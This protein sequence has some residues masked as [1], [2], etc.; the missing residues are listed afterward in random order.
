METGGMKTALSAAALALSLAL[1]GCGGSSGGMDNTRIE[2][3]TIDGLVSTASAAVAKLKGDGV[4]DANVQAAASAVQAANRAVAANEHLSDADEQRYED[5]IATLDQTV[6]LASDRLAAEKKADQA[7]TAKQQAENA[8]KQA[9]TAKQQAE[10]EK[11][12]ADAEKERAEAA[13]R[14]AE[15]D[16]R[17]AERQ[18]AQKQAAED[19]KDAKALFAGATAGGDRW[20]DTASGLMV[21]ATYG[22]HTTVT[23]GN[24]NLNDVVK[25]EVSRLSGRNSWS[26]TEVSAPGIADGSSDTVVVYT[27]IGAPTKVEFDKAYGGDDGRLMTED[28][29][30]PYIEIKDTDAPDIEGTGFAT[31]NDPVDLAEDKTIPEGKPLTVPGKFAGVL[32]TYECTSDCYSQ[33]GPKNKGVLLTGGNWTFAPTNPKARVSVPAT[34]YSYF[35]W[36]LEKTDTNTDTDTDTFAVQ[37]FHRGAGNQVGGVTPSGDLTGTA[38]YAGPAVGQYALLRD[39]G[40]SHVGGSFTATARLTAVFDDPDKVTGKINN[41]RGD[42]SNSSMSNWEVRLDSSDGTSA[43]WYVG[44]N[45]RTKDGEGTFAHAFRN[46]PKEDG[47]GTPTA[48]TGTWQ[49]QHVLDLNGTEQTTGHMIGAFGATKQ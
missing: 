29:K 25:S 8:R 20:G 9:E 15:E 40:T 38:D 41:F 17:E 23:L 14:Q 26:G 21:D 34:D 12:Q 47:S 6:D 31:G 28:D 49:T 30:K 43:I 37:V 44:D 5:A 24:R 46:A 32:G 7:E 27:N 4:T 18:L 13:R 39:G 42:P 2:M 3:Q 16:E 36:W 11:R 48:L 33:I 10:A 1:A 19:L 35:G 45:K 22:A